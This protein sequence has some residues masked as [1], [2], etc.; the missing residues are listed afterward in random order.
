[1][2]RF[3]DSRQR[4]GF[5]RRPRAPGSHRK[6]QHYLRGP[7]PSHGVDGESVVSPRGQY[8]LEHRACLCSVNADL[9]KQETAESNTTCVH[10]CHSCPEGVDQPC[11][12][13]VIMSPVCLYR[14]CCLLDH[15]AEISEEWKPCIPHDS[16]HLVTSGRH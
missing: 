3:W 5:K 15:T 1:M 2:H 14:L 8:E 10:R 13:L 11:Q 6:S 9:G 4:E 7:S 12:C 16:S